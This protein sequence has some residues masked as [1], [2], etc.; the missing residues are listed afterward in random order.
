MALSGLDI[1]KLLPKTNCRKCGFATCL[2]FA[3]QLAK[4]AV[5]ID[6]CPYLS[7]ETKNILEASSQPPIKLV[8]VGTGDSALQIGN[9]TVMFRHEEK[10]HHPCGIGF[11]LKDSLSPAEL[12]TS[13]EKISRLNFE[14]VGQK[15]EVNLVALKQCGTA[16]KFIAAL[17]TVQAATALG[18]VLISEDQAALK[19]A[20][21]LVKDRKPLIFGA[22]KKN[23]LALGELAKEYNAGLVVCAGDL[24]EI[25]ALTKELSAKGAGELII[26]TGKKPLQQKLW[27]LTQ[28]RRQALK[29][30]NR[31]LGYPVL[32]VAQN[33]DPLR[34]AVEAATYISKYA[35]IVLVSG[36]D[37][38]EALS[39]LTLRQNIYTDPQKPLQIEPKVYPIGQVT[40]KSPVLITTN[41]SLS[42]YTVLGEVEASKVPTYIISIDT[43]G[44]SVL[45]AWAAEK[46]TPAKIADFLE[47]T[48]IRE[49]LAHKR[50]VIPG[51]VAVMSGD[52]EDKSGWEVIVGP[53]EAAGIPAF[54]KK[55]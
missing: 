17:K 39:L 14:R 22:T 55:I 42:Y 20:L 7:E 31:A 30:S 25:A 54:L 15:L 29:K 26:D 13:L 6:K 50:I 1:Y 5:G 37:S 11:I 45:T 44:M 40:E 46:F 27:D 32:A 49:N 52:L 24:E 47:K 12:K 10:F 35:G 34:E 8:T 19:E 38:W 2:A 43:E 4:K 41:F 33:D 28:I 3:M 53:K 21:Q 16:E 23:Y 48:G 51:Y 36:M 18:I 9:E